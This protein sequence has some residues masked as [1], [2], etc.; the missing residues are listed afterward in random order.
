LESASGDAVRLA[1]HR[2]RRRQIRHDVDASATIFLVRV[3]STLRGRIVDLSLSGCRI[4]T[5]ERFPVGIYTRIEAEFC[6]QGLNF[7][8][9]GV[10]QAI[11]D[12]NIIG[13]RFLDLS[14]RKRQQ[15]A[16]LIADI[17]K[18]RATEISAEAAPAAEPI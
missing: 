5:E 15:I 1:S 3:G 6:C 12:R 17:D 18:A 7:R 4:R 16:E 8:L 10:I 14:E 13:I 9:G 11:H 2:D